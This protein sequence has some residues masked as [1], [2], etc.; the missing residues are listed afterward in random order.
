MIVVDASILAPA[1][2]DDRLYRVGAALE[3]ALKDHWGGKLLD[4]LAD[5]PAGAY[6]GGGER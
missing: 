2:A 3:Q 4:Q 6:L 5:S 1:L